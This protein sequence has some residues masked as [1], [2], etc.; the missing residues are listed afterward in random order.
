MSRLVL[1]AAMIGA[2]IGAVPAGA[3]HSF[4]MFDREKQVTLKGTVKEFQWT[5]PHVFI[6]VM[7]PGAGG[8]EE[9]W[10]VEGGSPNMLFR[11]GWEP[12]VFK[13]GDKVTLVI[14]P[15]KS[16]ERGGNFVF[17]QLPSG[18]TLGNMNAR[19]PG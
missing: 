12:T 15:L 1:S 9:E 4:A 6:Q 19:A 10:S 14:N 11:S 7:V 18:K 17:T 13:P 8:K 5:N 3:H 2:L 16:G